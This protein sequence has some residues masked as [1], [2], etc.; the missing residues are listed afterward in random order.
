MERVTRTFFRF[1]SFLLVNIKGRD[2]VMRVYKLDYV[3]SSAPLLE[4]AWSHR[5]LTSSR[6]EN[7]CA[8]LLLDADAISH[9]V[10]TPHIVRI[11]S[12]DVRTD[13]H[14]NLLVLF[15]PQVSPC[16]TSLRG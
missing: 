4:E 7:E 14:V 15:E 5:A 13:E 6:A 10:Y 8:V 12:W 9:I 1:K 2:V 11:M 3:S 16:H